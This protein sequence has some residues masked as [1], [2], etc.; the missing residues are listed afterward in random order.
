MKRNTGT[1]AGLLLLSI[2]LM[3]FGPFTVHE[4][5]V[6]GILAVLLVMLVYLPYK[7]VLPIA[8][9][10][11]V[12][13]TNRLEFETASIHTTDRL[14]CVSIICR[15][16]PQPIYVVTNSGSHDHQGL[17]YAYLA[18]QMGCDMIAITQWTDQQPQTM[19]VMNENTKF[20]FAGTDF[21]ELNRFGERKF[22]EEI[23]CGASLTATIF[24][25]ADK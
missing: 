3:I 12:F 22:L 24:G 6:F 2:G 19:A 14:A 8:L 16:L 5:Y 23:N 9:L 17:G 18:Q 1:L 21:Y 7:V 10:A 20:D 13:W 11:T 4:H 25:V 15:D